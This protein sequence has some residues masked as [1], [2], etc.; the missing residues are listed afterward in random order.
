MAKFSIQA[1]CVQF[2][3]VEA[4]SPQEAERKFNEQKN[5]DEAF[6]FDAEVI[7]NEDTQAVF[8]KSGTGEWINEEFEEWF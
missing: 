8:F 3:D 1:T 7:T 6:R 5:N 4:N 2:F